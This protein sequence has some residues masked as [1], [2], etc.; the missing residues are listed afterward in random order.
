MKTNFPNEANRHKVK[1]TTSE[2]KAKDLAFEAKAKEMTR[3]PR[4]AEVCT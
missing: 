2:A 1:A 4:G 3:S